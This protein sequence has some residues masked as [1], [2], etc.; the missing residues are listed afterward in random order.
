MTSA[1]VNSGDEVKIQRRMLVSL[2]KTRT[3]IQNEVDS[4]TETEDPG[5]CTPYE[6]DALLYIILRASSKYTKYPRE[7]PTL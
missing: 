6:S 4:Y 5:R 2:T 1:R 7:Q 3:F